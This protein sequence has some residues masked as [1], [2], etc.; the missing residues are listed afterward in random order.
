MTDLS[1]HRTFATGKQKLLGHAAMLAFAA[2]V[3]GS[4]SVGALAAPHIGPAA[5]NAARFVFGT[6][7]MAVAA[8]VF[9][10]GRVP[11]PRGGW[12]YI[13]LGGLMAIFFVTMFMALKIT[14]PVSAGAVFTLMPIMS[15]GFGWLF[16]GQ[17]PRLVIIASLLIAGAGAVWVIFK[18]DLQ[19]LLSFDV[20]RGEAI[21]FI[22]CVCH[23]AYA[24]L[25]RRLNRGEPV[26]AFALWTL[27]AT[28]LV[29]AAYGFFEILATDWADLPL[30]VWAAIAYLSVFTTAGTFFL[31]QF[32]SMR[33]PASKVLTYGYLN[34]TFVI[35]Y[36]GLAGHGWVSASVAVGAGIT[37]VALLVLALAPDG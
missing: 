13:L 28:G 34:P 29:I 22:G 8:F 1:L 17:K 6:A 10:K 23:A 35:L 26:M 12:R 24:P 36:E 20:G 37:I 7:I 19:A 11:P 9:L 31:L 2:L 18:G 16:L 30:I 3:A 25:V 5:I 21:F 27:A 32:A 4:F 14:D 15:T 33:L